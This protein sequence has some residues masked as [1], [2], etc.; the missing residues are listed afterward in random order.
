MLFFILGLIRNIMQKKNQK[1]FDMI[2]KIIFFLLFEC[3][4]L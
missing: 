2:Y 4:L 3:N 1:D